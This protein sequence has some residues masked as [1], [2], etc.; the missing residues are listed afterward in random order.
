VFLINIVASSIR[1]MTPYLYGALGGIYAARSGI[2]NIAIEGMMLIGAF[3]GVYGA[4]VSGSPWVGILF[5]VLSGVLSGALLAFMSVHVGTNQ[6]VTGTVINLGA[7]GLTSFLFAQ[8]FGQIAI[9]QIE[10]LHIM[11][12]PLLSE[13]PVLG[14]MF[15][16]NS[17][18]TYMAF[19]L[20]PV[21]WWFFYKTPTGLNV[22]AVGEN[23]SAAD[24]LGVRVYIV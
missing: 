22:R 13:I 1:I 6:I 14:P 5:A 7:V 16:N 23:P 19:L 21:T 4:Y 15:F 2:T 10:K 3:T 24:S 12:V 9:V 8:T 11:P 20:V 18:L 17:M